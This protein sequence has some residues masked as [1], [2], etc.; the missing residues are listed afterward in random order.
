MT[1]KKLVLIPPLSFDIENIDIIKKQLKKGFIKY[2]I[3]NPNA[4]DN[5]QDSV[6][7]NSLS[8]IDE[9]RGK[10][11]TNNSHIDINSPAKSNEPLL[12]SNNNINLD[13]HVVK[14]NKIKSSS[15]QV[16]EII[17][18]LALCHNVT[19]I[20]N[21][22][23]NKI[24]YHASSPDEVAL[25]KFTEL[26]G[27]VLTQRTN[28][29]IKLSV[30]IDNE[31]YSLV[32][33][34]LRVF[35]FTSESKRMAIIVKCIQTNNIIFLCKGA[36]SVMKNIVK[37]NDW[38]DEETENVAREGLRTL[39]F[40]KKYLTNNEYIEW[41]DRYHKASVAMS[42]RNIQML[43]VR[44]KLE[45]DMELLGISGVEDKLQNN[46]TNTLEILRNAKIKIWMLTGIQ[47]VTT[48]WAILAAFLYANLPC[49]NINCV[50]CSKFVIL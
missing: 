34:I 29:M 7:S 47:Y 23:N 41:E 35:P 5:M 30:Y 42:N 44:Q 43:N 39:V 21:N 17:E 31:V 36:E 2:M 45:N 46:V 26:V 20:I 6:T 28:N 9:L 40:S 3:N 32:Y 14:S 16:W 11:N 1:F 37:L 12:I 8:V 4:N 33:D 38:L 10:N 24:D 13:M 49:H 25:V 19:P 48:N 15:K 27:V 50:I 18:A 22:E